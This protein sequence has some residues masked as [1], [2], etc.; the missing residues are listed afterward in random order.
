MHTDIHL[1]TNIIGFVVYYGQKINQFDEVDT[2]LQIFGTQ[3]QKMVYW[4]LMKMLRQI[5]AILGAHIAYLHSFKGLRIFLI[6][7]I[8]DHCKKMEYTTHKRNLDNLD[9]L[10]DKISI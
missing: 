7:F 6:Y 2:C 8:I 3:T 4:I 5:D 1:L 10:T 9:R